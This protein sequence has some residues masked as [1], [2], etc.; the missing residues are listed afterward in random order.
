MPGRILEIL[1]FQLPFL[2]Q[3][4]QTRRNGVGPVALALFLF[5]PFFFFPFCCSRTG[6]SEEDE[7]GEIPLSFFRGA[8]PSSSDN[9]LYVEKIEVLCGLAPPPS[10]FSSFF[11]FLFPQRPRIDRSS[12]GCVEAF[13]LLLPSLLA[14]K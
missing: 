12:R 5:F 10:F 2:T 8:L 7:R 11:F 9:D 3:F 13:F 4:G 6:C 1:F 14:A